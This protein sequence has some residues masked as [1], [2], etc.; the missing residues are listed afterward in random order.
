MYKCLECGHI[1]D[2]GE[3]AVWTENQ[4]ECHGGPAFERFSG[5]PLCKGA[6]E[7]TTRCKKCSGE[8]LE[9]E[10]YEG[11]CEDCLRYAVTYDDFLAYLMETEQLPLFMFETVWDT[12]EPKNVSDKLM[13]VLR[14][15]Y[16][17]NKADDLIC[18]KT[19]FMS[20]CEKFV[21]EDD[22]E[23][24]RTDYAEWLNSKKGVK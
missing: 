11:L 5:C 20:L 19:A 17:R 15:Q 4:G 12:Q 6:Y 16:L 3:Q 22:G 14:E 13:V 23:Y 9:D 1:F 21:I 24:G 10:L 18:N 8:F 2:D 7:E